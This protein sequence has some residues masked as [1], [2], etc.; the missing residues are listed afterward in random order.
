MAIKNAAVIGRVG[1]RMQVVIPKE[2]AGQLH[3]AAGDFVALE[4]RLGSIVIRPQKLV[5]A[6]DTLTP[7]ETRLLR[8]AEQQMRLG[9][10]VALSALAH[11]LERTSRRRSRKTA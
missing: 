2:I 8:K 11:E 5:G 7:S 4:R 6:D 1:Q 3:L 10:S 9:H